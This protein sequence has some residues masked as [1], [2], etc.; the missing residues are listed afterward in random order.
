ML[1]GARAGSLAGRGPHRQTPG[2]LLLPRGWKQLCLWGLGAGGTPAGCGH[3]QV[4]GAPPAMPPV[5]CRTPCLQRQ[6][7]K[8]RCT[9]SPCSG[10]ASLLRS[11]SSQLHAVQARTPRAPTR[12]HAAPR[13]CGRLVGSPGL[14][15][16][17]VAPCHHWFAPEALPTGSGFLLMQRFAESTAGFGLQ[18]PKLTLRK[19]GSSGVSVS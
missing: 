10:E 6:R 13:P 11:R 19:R 2:Q 7:T 5:G 17:Q 1:V 8:L 15:A 18:E 4:C 16:L 9:P 14:Q 12:P 3:P